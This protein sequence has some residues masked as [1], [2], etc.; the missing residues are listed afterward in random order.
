MN[1]PRPN[2]LCRELHEF[3]MIAQLI[4]KCV[5]PGHLYTIYLVA[6]FTIAKAPA[7]LR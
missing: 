2:Q 6:V 4:S 5:T 1:T 7:I 3:R